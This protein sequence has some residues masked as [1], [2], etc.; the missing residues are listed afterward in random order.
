MNADNPT[1]SIYNIRN[2][3]RLLNDAYN[4]EELRSLALEEFRPV[5]DDYSEVK[6]SEL[7][8]RIYEHVERKGQI[9]HLL[10][11]VER[12]APLQYAS[13]QDRLMKE[14]DVFSEQTLALTVT[15]VT[16]SITLD[17]RAI[18]TVS[19]V[20]KGE[21]PVDEILL[22]HGRTLLDEPFSLDINQ[23][24]EF[25]LTSNYKTPGKKRKRLSLTGIAQNG[26][27]VQVEA[28]ATLDVIER[29]ETS[30]LNN[31]TITV[32]PEQA[33]AIII[34][35][36]FR[37]ELLH[38]PAGPFLMGSNPALDL[39]ALQNEQ[40]QHQV[41][42][43]EYYVSTYPITNGQYAA[44]LK[45][46]N[47]QG[48]PKWE[49]K[50]SWFRSS[51]QYPVGERNHPAIYVSW[52]DATAFCEWLTTETEYTF[53]LPTEAEWEKA[54]RGTQGFIYPWGNDWDY[55]RLNTLY[56]GPNSP[57]PVGNYSP[58]GDSPY[59]LADMAGNV[60]EWCADWYDPDFY[61]ARADEDV[62]DPIGPD[63][64]LKRVLR[65][66]AWSGD[67]YIVRC[68]YRRSHDPGARTNMYGFRVV[69]R[70]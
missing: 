18:W 50:E 12:D 21:I 63:E 9:P 59:G 60:W 62:V 1:N 31:P 70:L 32:N 25:T 65:G 13:Y 22:R 14:V 46:T 57:T 36:P 17:E 47:H 7:I 3:Q 45:A 67:Q 35:N 51:V 30:A 37:L 11:L 26:E 52:D 8:R 53:S 29:D 5:Y 38:I 55:T 68:A 39:R 15:P 16:E 19:L 2:I 33:E 20:N 6:K 56:H 66:G 4:L 43:S 49:V 54:A 10:S 27:A 64:Q 34:T 61:A 42:L 69:I 41:H 44:F 48:H 58:Q 23:R 24:R 40:P 28:S